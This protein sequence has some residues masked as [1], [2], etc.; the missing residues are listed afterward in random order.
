MTPEHAAVGIIDLSARAPAMLNPD[1][2][3]YGASVPKIGILLGYF[4]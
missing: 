2:E 1:R 3:T 4:A